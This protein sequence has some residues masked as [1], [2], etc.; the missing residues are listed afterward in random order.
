ML[1]RDYGIA[2]LSFDRFLEADDD[3]ET[4]DQG[5]G[6]ISRSNRAHRDPENKAENQERIEIHHT[7]IWK[8]KKTHSHSLSQ[9]LA[10][11]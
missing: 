9:S 11:M 6:G 2:S 5:R 10:H 3:K 8:A 1:K 4:E 7:M